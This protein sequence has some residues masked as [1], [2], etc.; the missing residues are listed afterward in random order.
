MLLYYLAYNI[1]KSQMS[2]IMLVRYK[3]HHLNF[4][5]YILSTGGGV[6]NW[7]RVGDSAVDGCRGGLLLAVRGGCLVVVMVEFVSSRSH[8]LWLLHA[9]GVRRYSWVYI[10]MSVLISSLSSKVVGSELGSMVYGWLPEECVLVLLEGLLLEG[11]EEVLERVG[12]VV[13]V[14]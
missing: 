8:W 3:C 5:I 13:V 6:G 12:G 4:V 2:T 14:V 1:G 11:I 10:S 7:L 9:A